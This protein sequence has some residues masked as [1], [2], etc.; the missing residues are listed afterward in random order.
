MTFNRQYFEQ[1][2]RN[3]QRHMIDDRAIEYLLESHQRGVRIELDLLKLQAKVPVE[4][5]LK[6][7]PLFESD[8][9]SE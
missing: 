4:P 2:A 8:G 5:E 9:E 7:A 1:I 6:Q 3:W